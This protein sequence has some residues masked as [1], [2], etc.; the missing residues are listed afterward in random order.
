MSEFNLDEMVS[1]LHPLEIRL[2]KVLPETGSLLEGE[3]AQAAAMEEARFRRA[4]EW[5]RTKELIRVEE[6]GRERVVRVTDLGRGYVEDGVP[7]DRIAREVTAR[8]AVP[9]AEIKNLAGL[10]PEESF[11]AIGKLKEQGILVVE[12]GQARIAEGA[13]LSRVGETSR[14]LERACSEDALRF[15]EL[16]PLQ[17][18]L[19]SS[20]VHKRFRAKGLFWLE[21][22]VARRLALTE[23]GLAVR[24]EA[25]RRGRTGEELSRLTPEM[26][27]DGSWRGRTFRK[28]NIELAPPRITAAKKHAYREFL[29]YVKYKLI[30]MGFE[31]M[32]GPLVETEFWNMDALFMPQFHAARDIH[33]VYFVKEPAYARSLDE[34]LLDAVAR[35]HEGGGGSGSRGWGYAFDRKRAHRLVLRSQGT[36][37]SARTLASNPKV[38]GKYFAMARCFRYD[39]VDATHACDFMQI[40]GIALG[41]EIN[42]RTLLGLLKLFAV[43]VAKSEE[44]VFAPAYFPFTEPSVEAHIRHPDLGWM[45]LGGA[46]I[47]RPEVT[48]PFGIEVPV[49]AW[50]L[51][52]DRMAMVALGVKDIRDLFTRDLDFVREQRIDM[53]MI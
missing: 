8:G 18:E 33:D 44:V 24:A 45:E 15:E 21:E 3:A 46:G 47:F 22:R 26:L 23:R 38:P 11:P 19:V 48:A 7:E 27:A 2:L 12:K 9:M 4:L 16:T 39:T 50:G 10:T 14:V 49:M 6:A 28:Y 17:Q 25:A 43:E 36:A 40:E 1:G 37:L 29:D 30:S 52:L 41:E 34:E 32:Q 31:E 13:D 5:L 42:F 20:H 53:E 35:A 51:G